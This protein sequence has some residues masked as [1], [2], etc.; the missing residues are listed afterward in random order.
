MSGN[1]M[2]RSDQGL[3]VRG[4]DAMGQNKA[5]TKWV[6]TNAAN[7]ENMI[8]STRAAQLRHEGNEHYPSFM[9][10]FERG[11]ETCR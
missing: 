9:A 10:R 4:R 8:I 3:T 5:F 6:G 1:Y 7:T 11:N 2:D